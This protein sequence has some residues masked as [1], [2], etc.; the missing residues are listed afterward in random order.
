MRHWAAVG[1]SVRPLRAVPP[2]VRGLL[3]GTLALQLGWHALLPDPAGEARPIPPA[4]PADVLAVAALGEP[5]T[6]AA[7]LTLWLKTR[8]DQPGA[9]QTF[10]EL[11]FHRVRAWLETIL[12][13]DPDSQYPLMLAVR[14]Y[15][16]VVNPGQQRIMLDF[17]HEAFRE[18]PAQRWRWLA[19]ASIIARHRL[20]DLDL[21]LAYAETLAAHTR[22]GEAPI[23][24]RDLQSLILEEM[25]E[26]EAAAIVIGGLLDAGEIEDPRELEFLRQRLERLRMRE[27]DNND[28]G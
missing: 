3:A 12:A 21:A 4:P 17:V 23:W 2:W 27:Q 6:L 1:V 19:E 5:P 24:A 11:D 10:H 25:G 20:E 9:R 8:D 22:P 28:N 13:I 18:R 7:G 14:V 16:Q 15:G 26:Y